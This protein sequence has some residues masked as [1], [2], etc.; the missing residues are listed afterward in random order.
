MGRVWTSEKQAQEP[1]Y[2]RR[3]TN[4]VHSTSCYHVLPARYLKKI[5]KN[6]IEIC[7]LY[8]E[9]Q[10]LSVHSSRLVLFYHSHHCVVILTVS[11]CASP[12]KILAMVAFSM[13]TEQWKVGTNRPHRR[14]M[15]LISCTFPELVGPSTTLPTCADIACV[16]EGCVCVGYSVCECVR[17]GE[18]RRG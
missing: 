13:R 1:S 8:C 17:G 9:V 16:C 18:K 3:D 4:N 11:T 10:D 6:V 7:Q 12:S 5:T 15:P 2:E 14:P